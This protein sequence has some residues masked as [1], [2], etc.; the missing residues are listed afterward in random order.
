METSYDVKIWGIEVRTGSRSTTYRVRWAVGTRRHTKAAKTKALADSFRSELLSAARR[1]E[2]FDIETGLPASRRP[3]PAAAP[4]W[5]Q[6]AQSFLDDSWDRL[7]PRSRQSIAEALCSITWA[8]LPD[9]SGRPSAAEV[10]QV[11]TMFALTRRQRR[12][13]HMDEDSAAT[14]A[15]VEGH[16]PLVDGLTD[17]ALVRAT[18]D[19]LT[20]NMDG[21]TA[22]ANTITRRRTVFYSVLSHAVEAGH[23]P[24]NPLDAI[25]WRA[26]KKQTSLDTRTVINHE[27]AIR[28]LDAVAAYEPRGRRYV[29]FFGCM[30]YAALRPSEVVALRVGDLVLPETGWGEIH[31]ARSNPAVSLHWTDS[32]RRQPRQLKHRAA[33]DVR[34]VPCAPQLVQLLQAHLDEYAPASEGRVFY[35]S[36]GGVLAE[37]GYTRIWQAARRRGLT[38]LEAASNLTRRPYDLRHA[39]VST[40][41]SAGV[42]ATQVAEW[43]GHSVAVLLRVYAKTVS[44]GDAISRERISRQLDKE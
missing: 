15:W 7:A 21:R 19:R 18:L 41:L 34:R 24:T 44:G 1:G 10:R 13:D 5:L 40:W 26:P 27:Q 32:Q 35:S 2:A 37:A 29:A 28:L 17:P 31:L 43:A 22:S 9:Q 42:D 30:Y 3:P 16:L 20:K 33:G 14:L 36:R 8:L 4:G 38:E 39:A 6:H 25:R 23:L 11:L 12:S